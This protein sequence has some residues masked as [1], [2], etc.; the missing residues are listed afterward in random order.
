MGRK[1][2]DAVG[3]YLDGKVG[4]SLALGEGF[5]HLVLET[6]A[7]IGTRGYLVEGNFVEE[8][9][10]RAAKRGFLEDG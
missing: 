7:E 2:D 9:G 4:R 8:G 5:E 10:R 1:K 3:D 6:E